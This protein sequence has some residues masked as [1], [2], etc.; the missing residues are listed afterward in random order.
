MVGT[1]GGRV[2]AGNS[3]I[4]EEEVAGRKQDTLEVLEKV[5]K[6]QKNIIKLYIHSQ[7][8]LKLQFFLRRNVQS[9]LDYNVVLV[10]SKYMYKSDQNKTLRPRY[11]KQNADFQEGVSQA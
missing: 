9:N 7:T 11:M 10:S 1:Q 4:L 8:D 6:V 5:L 2:V 3:N